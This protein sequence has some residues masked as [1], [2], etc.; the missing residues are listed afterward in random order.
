MAAPPTHRA[1]PP[2]STQTQNIQPSLP[3]HGCN[4]MSET[5]L[6]LQ[7]EKLRRMAMSTTPQQ[8]RPELYRARSRSSFD[9]LRQEPMV[10]RRE[11]RLS[12]SHAHAAQAAMIARVSP[13]QNI[14][15]L[16]L[17]SPPV[18]SQPTSPVQARGQQQSAAATQLQQA[19]LYA[20]LQK[21]A[22]SISASDWDSLLG[23]IEGGPLNIYDTMYG[24]P[25]L[26]LGT[27]ETPASTSSG[28]AW[29]PESWDLSGFNLGDFGPG[30]AQSVLS[31]SEDS[32]SSGDAS[33]DLGLNGRDYTRGSAVSGLLSI[34]ANSDAFLLDGLENFG[35]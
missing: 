7:Q 31:L 19:Q 4:G 30:T 24:G 14:D 3:R 25:G 10:A 26:T 35:L 29:S 27:T 32:L 20:Q 11:H 34:A 22:A 21:G 5:D 18:Q 28:A 2:A 9:S 1:S 33:S 17:N 12:L 13:K 23:S 8:Q 6:L 16:S 15:Y